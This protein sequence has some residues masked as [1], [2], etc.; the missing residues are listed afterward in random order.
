MY[1]VCVC[2]CVCNRKLFAKGVPPPE[3]PGAA[4]GGPQATNKRQQ[5]AM[6][7]AVLEAQVGVCVCVSCIDV[8]RLP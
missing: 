7:V 4:A 8:Q 3:A 6:E 5:Q 2:V 1:C